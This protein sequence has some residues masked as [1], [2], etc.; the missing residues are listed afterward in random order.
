[1]VKILDDGQPII[2]EE[3][4]GCLFVLERSEGTI[5]FRV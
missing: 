5:G 3:A 1:M 2:I 4:T